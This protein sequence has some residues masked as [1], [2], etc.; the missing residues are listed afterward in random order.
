MKLTKGNLDK[1]R[2]KLQDKGIETS[3]MFTT[4]Y[5]TKAYKK[6]EKIDCFCPIS[7]KLDDQTFTIPLHPGL[8]S[9]QIDYVI[10]EI[11]NQ[12]V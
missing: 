8:T 11:K 12:D 2:K 4:V 3:P 5:K 9:K 6:L 1:F 10:K 7:E